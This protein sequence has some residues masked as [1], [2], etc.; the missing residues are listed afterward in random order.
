MTLSIPEKTQLIVRPLQ[1]RDLEAME[2]L[3]SQG[4]GQEISQR[5]VSI[6]R[7]LKQVRSW[8][9][10]RQF[11]SLLPYSYQKDR[12]IYVAERKQKILGLIQVSPCNRTETTWRVE[13][14]L[15][16]KNLAELKTL[17]SQKEVG[18]QLL[19]YCLE[20]I[21]E[22]RTWML[23]VNVNDKHKL[24]LY[25]ENGFQPLAQMTYW[26][27]P[28]PLIAKLAQQ[29]SNLP[30]LL[31]ISNAD[32]PLLYQLDCVSMPPLLRQ[33]FDRDVHDFKTGFVEST[34]I[35]I[36]QWLGKSEEFKGYIFEPQRK[37]AIGYFQ[38]KSYPDN[39]NT[40]QAKLTVNAAYTWLYPELIVQMAQIAYQSAAKSSKLEDLTCSLPSLELVSADYQPEREEFLNELGASPIEHTLLMSRSVW[41]K[42]RETKRL[43]GL[44]LSEVLQ[45]LKPARTP[46]PS[47][48]SLMK[49]QA[50]NYQRLGHKD[51]FSHKSSD[52]DSNED[53]S[54]GSSSVNSH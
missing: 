2:D 10:L 18:S 33:I 52:R 16:N 28:S 27:L 35:K 37:A 6:D 4:Q 32:A 14:V 47:R 39:S 36:L 5:L 46:I 13:R 44:Q 26:R 54:T 15:V 17:A 9:G 51:L 20:N 7:D 1:Y 12:R 19:R 24:A 22:A 3:I 34:I 48:I 23:E 38:L 41:H 45:G 50:N 11:L 53:N 25:R 40:Y 43:E 29:D 49:S 21:W 30:N 8:Y 42:I 31:P